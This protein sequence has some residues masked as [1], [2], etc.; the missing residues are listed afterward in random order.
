MSLLRLYHGSNSEFD[1]V[2]ISKSRNR[3]DFGRGFYTTTIKEQA[4][5]WARTIFERYGGAGKHLYVFDFEI[6][7]DLQYKEFSG[8]SGEWLE[9]IKENR[10]KGGVQ[11]GYDVIRGP[12]ANDNTMLVISLFLDGTLSEAAAL[13]E[14]AFFKASDQVSV[15]TQKA[16][17]HLKMIE[18]VT[19]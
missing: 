15:H 18:R 1:V 12:V 5:H 7:E 17:T 16:L 3:R 9:I 2:D 13:Y 6:T 11:H 8:L 14:L 19:L 10:V 4:E